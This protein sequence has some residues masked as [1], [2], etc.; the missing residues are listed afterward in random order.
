[1]WDLIQKVR[2]AIF[3]VGGIIML[4]I[5]LVAGTPSEDKLKLLEGIPT[6]SKTFYSQKRLTLQF[7]VGDKHT[8]YSSSDPHFNEVLEVS[9]SGVPVKLWIQDKGPG[10][11][12]G[13]LYKLSTKDKTIV[14]YDETVKS[15]SFSKTFGTILGLILVIF[16]ASDLIRRRKK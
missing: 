7:N 4:F 9:K 8:Q 1:M 3:L 14:S 15:K 2:S 10:S 16:G 11:D 6:Q 5:V 13:P 12:W